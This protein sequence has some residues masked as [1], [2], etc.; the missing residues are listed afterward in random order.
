LGTVGQRDV[1]AT[2]SDRL[3][4]RKVMRAT[5]ARNPV[6]SFWPFFPDGGLSCAD[7]R[8]LIGCSALSSARSDLIEQ[9]TRWLPEISL[10]DGQAARGITVDCRSACHGSKL[11]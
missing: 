10:M 5:R 6:V 2:V 8:D 9:H 7:E 11:R 3:T 1:S 4:T